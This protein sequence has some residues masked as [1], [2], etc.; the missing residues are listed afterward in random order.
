MTASDV[1][2]VPAEYEHIPVV[3]DNIRDAD[4]QELFDFCQ[5]CPTEAIEQSFFAAKR[6]WTGLVDDIP[7][8]MFGVTQGEGTLGIPWLVTTKDIEQHSVIFLRRCKPVVH[9]MTQ[10]FTRLENYV[11]SGNI[12]AIAW[13][14]WLGFTFGREEELGPFSKP[15][16]KFWMLS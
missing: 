4:R 1:R 11:A 12:L 10:G 13:L 5:L 14:K 15:F 2:I 6:S 9:E 8:C 16:I 7:V 3:A